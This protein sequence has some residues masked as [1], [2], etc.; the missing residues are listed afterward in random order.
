M[1]LVH[2]MASNKCCN[3]HLSRWHCVCFSSPFLRLSHSSPPTHPPPKAM[4]Q[5][6]SLKNLSYYCGNVYFTTMP[7]L[8]NHCSTITNAGTRKK[9]QHFHFPHSLL[10]SH[11]RSPG[12]NPENL[13]ENSL[14]MTYI[15]T[16][17]VYF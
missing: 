12:S 15:I 3:D 17:Q 4:S 1:N 7:L 2:K 8:Y 14:Q 11:F 10:S 16:Q 5:K 9:G 13:S 6:F